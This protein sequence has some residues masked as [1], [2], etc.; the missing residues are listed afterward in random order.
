[1][2]MDNG[3]NSHVQDKERGNHYFK[4]RG[5]VH[6]LTKMILVRNLSKYRL[7]QRNQI[8]LVRNRRCNNP[9]RSPQ[10][11]LLPRDGE[12]ATSII[13]RQQSCSVYNDKLSKR[14]FRGLRRSYTM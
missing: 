3:L 9:L 13:L 1:M 6:L 5:K 8:L 7:P 10:I 4:I 2:G 12:I 11:L 14:S